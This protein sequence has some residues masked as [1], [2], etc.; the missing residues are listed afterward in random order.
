MVHGL[1]D[2]GVKSIAVV[3]L[4]QVPGVRLLLVLEHNRIAEALSEINPH[5]DDALLYNEAR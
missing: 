3:Y 2:G 1:G 5:F 4:L